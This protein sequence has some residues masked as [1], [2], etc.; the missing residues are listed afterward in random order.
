MNYFAEG[1]NPRNDA[2]TCGRSGSKKTLHC[3]KCNEW[4]C[5]MCLTESRRF[6]SLHSECKTVPLSADLQHRYSVL[7]DDSLQQM[8]TILRRV[9]ETV[10][11]HAADEIAL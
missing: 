6:S 1:K 9:T 10:N 2:L 8:E 5:E 7:N 3:L 4:H 11:M